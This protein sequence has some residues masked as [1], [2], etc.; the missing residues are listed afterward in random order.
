MKIKTIILL[1]SLVLS[2]SHAT[3]Q[4]KLTKDTLQ[5]PIIGFNFGVMTPL[6][7]RNAGNMIDLYKPPYLNYGIDVTYK[8]KS[9]WLFSVDGNLVMGSD[10]LRDRY[11]RM[12]SVYS[13]DSIPFVIGTGGTDAGASCFNRALSFRAGVGK[14]VP[15]DMQRNPNSGISLRLYGGLWYQKTIFMLNKEH[16]PQLEGDYARLYDHKRQG[17]SLTQSV[18]YWFMSNESNFLNF[19]VAAELTQLWTQ[20]S[21]EY[22][23][24]NL[25]GLQGPDESNYFDLLFNIKV[26]WM[27]PIKGKSTY[28]YY[29]Y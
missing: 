23:I 20:S 18:G 2:I 10:N 19:Y 5:C 12:G 26:C 25:L 16:A 8:R 3:A 21:R 11:E 29:F 28:D 17:F 7:S 27:I 13:G 6:E 14:I 15:L 24:D 22:V 4:V 1:A 9:N